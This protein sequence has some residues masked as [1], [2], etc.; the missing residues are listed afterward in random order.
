MV[1]K[2][3]TG[4]FYL[5]HIANGE[6][7]ENCD[8]LIACDLDDTPVPGYRFASYEQGYGDMLGLPDTSTIR[9]PVAR[10]H[11]AGARRPVRHRQPEADRGGPPPRITAQVEQA[12][13][14]GTRR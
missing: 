6:G 4:R 7:T 11:G 2:R 8:Y 3:A 9:Y 10:S 1:G 14:P 5:E 13:A 12:E